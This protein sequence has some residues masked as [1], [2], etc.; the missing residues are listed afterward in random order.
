MARYY[1]TTSG[2]SITGIATEYDIFT[3]YG[4]GA[5]TIVGGKVGNTF[6][7][8]VDEFTDSVSGGP[9]E[10]LIDYSRSDRGL[11]I[12]LAAGKV[13]ALF[14]GGLE[15]VIHYGTVAY[16]RGIEDVVGSR[17]NDTIKGTTGDNIIEGG[18]G[19]D[20]I[21]GH[22]GT[23]TASY[24]HSAAGVQVDLNNVTQHG[25]DAEGDQ[26]YSID[27]LI[28][29]THDDR[30]VGNQY[31]NT[32]EGGAGADYI[33]G[34]GGGLF[35]DFASYAHS[36]A[37]V[38]IDLRAAVQHGGD[39]EGDQL[40][41]IGS[42]IGSAYN[43][44][45]AG[46]DQGNSLEGGDG[47]DTFFHTL[48][49]DIVDGGAGSDTYVIG[50]ISGTTGVSVQLYDGSIVYFPDNGSP[51]ADN[52]VLSSIENVVGSQND[53]TLDGSAVDSTVG[54]MINGAGGG[55]TVYGSA[56]SDHLYGSG[57]NDHLYGGDG[58]D[59]LFGG[60]DDDW[61]IGQAGADRLDGGSGNNWADYG[62]SARAVEVH[63]AP[64]SNGFFTPDYG[65]GR[66]GDA[67]GDQLRNIQDV[68]GSNY[69]D[70]LIGDDHD[71]ILSGLGGNNTLNGGR[72]SDTLIAGMGDD[73]L[74]GGGHDIR[75]S[76]TFEFDLHGGPSVN[77][78]G[79]NQQQIGNDTIYDWEAGDRIVL[80]NQNASQVAHVDFSGADTL[81]R[82]DGVEGQITVLGVHA[83]YHDLFGL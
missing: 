69:D 71:N 41:N 83:G 21:D 9:G 13:T 66:G 1:G 11:T 17:F 60:D 5:D 35:G 45:I 42:V 73:R 46:N 14:G 30:L 81:V 33:D 12:D 22:G 78:V 47:D 32:I 79:T 72:G 65:T 26:L 43:D 19:A 51:F 23:D 67:D 6:V 20:K 58:I 25:G 40:Y 7:L 3:D 82:F 29:S 38:Q 50:Q 4:I 10:D 56:G 8:S 75:G 76:D 61:L 16:V 2:D 55:D 54:T 64:Q 63:L 59:F 49:D 53:D 62:G 39:A 68:R 48:G 31:V 36:A 28:G 34:D 70:I 27:N 44:K 18:A 37:G 57:G 77:A 24:A 52:V 74:Y 80:L 15:E